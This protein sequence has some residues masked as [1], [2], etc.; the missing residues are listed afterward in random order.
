MDQAKQYLDF[1][2]QPDNLQY[3]LDNTPEFSTLP[4]TGVKPK[5]DD[6]QTEFLNTYKAA[7]P[8]Y[9]DVVNYLNPQWIDIGKDMV[10]MF[11]GS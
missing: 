3:L 11:T 10:S 2:M 1:L 9:Q 5:W 4:F 6:A 7:T 8:V